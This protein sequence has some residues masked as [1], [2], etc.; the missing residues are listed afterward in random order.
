MGLEWSR[1]VRP[2]QA[3]QAWNGLGMPVAQGGLRKCA[4]AVA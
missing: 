2:F 4:S 1:S 3:S